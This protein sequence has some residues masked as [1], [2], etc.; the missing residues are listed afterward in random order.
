[1]GRR[2]LLV[3]VASTERVEAWHAE[4]LRRRAAGLLPA[5]VEIVPAARTVL[6]DGLD[7]PDALA[8]E[9]RGWRVPAVGGGEGPLVEVAVVYDGAD[10]EEVAALWGVTGAEAVRLHSA[11]EYRVGFCGFAPGFAYLTGLPERLA[12][13][14]RDTPRTRVPA[15]SV[16]VAGPYTGVYPQ[17]SPGGWQLLGRTDL[18]LWDPAREPAAL[19][20]PGTRVRFRPVA[21][22]GGA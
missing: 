7:R 12:V 13:P 1:M 10:L 20:A 11:I 6:L 15:G 14:R 5:E 4:L 22:E 17:P 18:R 21:A 3:E 9:M 16:A 19:L 2:A 8:A